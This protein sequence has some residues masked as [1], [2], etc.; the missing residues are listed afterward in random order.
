MH[1]CNMIY[2][3]CGTAFTVYMVVRSNQLEGQQDD[4]E[5]KLAYEHFKCYDYWWNTAT[6]VFWC[7]L[8][9]FLLYLLVRFSKPKQYTD[10][11]SMF[12]SIAHDST[13]L[14]SKNINQRVLDQS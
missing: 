11:G 9:M 8:D 2:F 10:S 3:V 1:L 5:G 4:C 7:Y 12:D 14:A 6:N 13:E